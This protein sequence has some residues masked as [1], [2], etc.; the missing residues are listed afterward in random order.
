LPGYFVR[1]FPSI[2]VN[3]KTAP[4][5]PVIFEDQL[6]LINMNFIYVVTFILLVIGLFNP[7]ASLFWYPKE[8]TRWISAIVYGGVL[9]LLACT[10][11]PDQRDRIPNSSESPIIDTSSNV[12]ITDTMAAVAAEAPNDPAKTEESRVRKKLQAKANRDWP[13]DYSTQEYWI[14]QEMDD[15]K[16]ML[17]I[18]DNPIKRQAERD[19]PY[20][21]STQR[22]WYVEQVAAK[23]RLS[24]E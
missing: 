19:W 5:K 13:N 24:Q 6:S 20:D 2:T 14:N 16:I 1:F 23:E 22:F 8:R 11:A 3:R 12:R 4:C 10:S 17:T 15:Y 9:L 18:P 7:H 21:F